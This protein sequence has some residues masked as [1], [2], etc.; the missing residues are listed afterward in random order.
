MILSDHTLRALIEKGEL[1]CEPLTPESVQPA[2]IDCR[3][4]SHFLLVENF[5]MQTIDM[6]SEIIYREFSGDSI[7]MHRA[8]SVFA[9]NNHGIRADCQTT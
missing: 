3:L 7:T 8:G 1:G 6:D 5:N 9:R 2:S 4:G